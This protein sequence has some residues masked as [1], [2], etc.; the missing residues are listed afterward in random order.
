MNGHRDPGSTRAFVLGVLSMW[1]GVFAPFAIYSSLRSLGRIRAAD[2]ALRGASLATAG[3][4]G[5]L[6]GFAV[7]VAGVLYWVLAA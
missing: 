2:G 1:F 7:I 5:G 4:A 3:L 6:L